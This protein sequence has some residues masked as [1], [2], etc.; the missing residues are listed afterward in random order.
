[1]KGR[2]TDRQDRQTY[3]SNSSLL[4]FSLRVME[5]HYFEVADFKIKMSYY[6]AKISYQ[7]T[8]PNKKKTSAVNIKYSSL[9]TMQKVKFRLCTKFL[10]EEEEKVQV[11]K[12]HVVLIEKSYLNVPYKDYIRPIL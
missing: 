9:R 5:S 8:G 10:N 12:Q 6:K 3:A 4:I 2:G 11:M 7:Q 1:M